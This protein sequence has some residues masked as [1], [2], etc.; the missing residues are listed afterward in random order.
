MPLKRPRP[1]YRTPSPESS[2]EEEGNPSRPKQAKVYTLPSDAQI[3]RDLDLSNREDHA[4]YTPTPFDLAKA[5]ANRKSLQEGTSKRTGNIKP[6]AADPDK[7]KTVVEPKQGSRSEGD[8]D[9]STSKAAGRDRGRGGAR[10]G[11]GRGRYP[12]SSGWTNAR[13]DHIPAEKEATYDNEPANRPAPA[14]KRSLLSEADYIVA[15]DTPAVKGKKPAPKRAKAVKKMAA[16][17][18]VFRKIRTLICPRLHA[19]AEYIA[20]A[21]AASNSQ[22]PI[23]QGLERQRK[24]PLKGQVKKSHVSMVSSDTDTDSNDKIPSLDDLI[25]GIDRSTSALL[26]EKE[27]SEKRSIEESIGVLSEELETSENDGPKLDLK[28]NGVEYNEPS[29]FHASA[30]S[31]AAAA[32]PGNCQTPSLRFSGPSNETD[33]INTPYDH[34][35][36][37]LNLTQASDPSTITHIP[38]DPSTIAKA[39]FPSSSSSGVL[40]YSSPLG[41]KQHTAIESAHVITPGARRA[42]MLEQKMNPVNRLE[43]MASIAVAGQ[44]NARRPY[45]ASSRKTVSLHTEPSESS[46]LGLSE[47]KADEFSY[48]PFRST[49]KSGSQQDL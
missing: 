49:S 14:K 24:L 32:G 9:V 12:K 31:N 39:H 23:I 1:V 18:P 36:P 34:H 35:D 40:P 10:G 7:P 17:K 29:F 30:T 15:A 37:H 5:Q 20:A 3:Y 4:I 13:G 16:D 26:K 42:D 44:A 38:S 28:R 46:K 6:A 22:F 41:G 47:C 21:N 48:I 19:R 45:N 25:R 11:R 43:R 33:Y 8:W 27:T 2:S